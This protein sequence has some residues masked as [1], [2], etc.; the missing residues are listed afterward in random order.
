M[1]DKWHSE[2][3]LKKVNKL[4]SKRMGK[5]MIHLQSAVQR[6]LSVGQPTRRTN[7]G[8]GGV[9]VLVG[10]DPSAPGDPPRVVTSRLRTS[11]TNNVSREGRQIVGRVGTNVKYGRRLELGFSGTDSRGRNINQAAR[12]YLRPS[13]V[14]TLPRLVGILTRGA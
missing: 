1:A 5:A 13:L 2:K 11:I 3:I 6:K 10:L 9:A 7:P 14:E 12:P 8:E 4:V